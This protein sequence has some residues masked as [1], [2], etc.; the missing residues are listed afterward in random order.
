M[1]INYGLDSG[2]STSGIPVLKLHGSLNWALNSGRV[3]PLLLG[4]YFQK[5]H[6]NPFHES[7]ECKIPIRTQLKEY[8]TKHTDIEV[9]AEP[10]IVPPTWN[11][12]EHHQILAQVW[13]RA[14]KELGEA[15]YIFIIG[16]SLSETDAFFR[17]LYALGTV[18]D[19]PLKR[20][21]I[22]NPDS[23]GEI[24]NRY[25]SLMGPGAKKRFNHSRLKFHNS[26][27]VIESYFPKS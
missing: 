10:V 27:G 17:L 24:H 9:E 14:A 15:E 20:I 18:G 13:G 19:T 7:G 26:I 3:I 8:F 5:Y 25:E 2:T 6:I 21:E 12:A 4:D 22:F 16:Y 11:K 23:S 1:G